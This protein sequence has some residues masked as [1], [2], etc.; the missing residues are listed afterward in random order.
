MD[1]RPI[2][3]EPIQYVQAAANI[4][5]DLRHEREKR[6]QD[7]YNRVPTKKIEQN[8]D[9]FTLSPEVQEIGY[10]KSLKRTFGR[11]EK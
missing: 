6:R 5:L 3:I 11:I 10:T 7:L 2:G 8:R 4:K 9:T 1:E